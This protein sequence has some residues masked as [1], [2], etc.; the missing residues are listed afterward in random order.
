MQA[1]GPGAGRTS[2]LNLL[3]TQGFIRLWRGAPA[4]LIGCVPSHAAYFSA[5]EACKERL[6]AN[7]AGHHPV[8]AA[9]SG[10]FATL[11]HDGVLTPMDVVKQRLQLGYYRGVWHCVTSITATEGLSALWR[12]Y[13]TTLAMNVPYAG[14]V[15]AANE[16]AKRALAPILGSDTTLLHLVSGACAGA[17]AGGATTPIDGALLGRLF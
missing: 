16:S 3:R 10:A 8:A 1:L 5:Y 2:F 7:A 9:S 14:T 11:L 6:G 17:L 13:P 15:V 12:S 4:V